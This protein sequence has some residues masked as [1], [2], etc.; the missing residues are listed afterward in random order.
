MPVLEPALALQTLPSPIKLRAAAVPAANLDLLRAVAVL[1]VYLAH[2]AAATGNTNFGSLG[3][4]GVILFF[5]HTSFVLMASLNR[6]SAS[7]PNTASLVRA[8]AVRR[9]FRIYP[10]S[11]ATVLLV[12]VTRIPKSPLDHFLW[13]GWRDLVSNLALTQNL[14]Y[15]RLSLDVLWS[16]PLE[17]QMYCLLPF[18]YLAI[19]SR[20]LLSLSFLVL[21]VVAALTLPRFTGRLVVFAYAP[22]FSA[23]VFGYDIARVAKP[24]LSSSLWPLVLL[25][26]IIAFNPHDDVSLSDK[27]WRAWLVS[28]AIGFAIPWFGEIKLRALRIASHVIAK[29]SYGIYLSH[30]I[31]FWFVF[32]N[33]ASFSIAARVLTLGSGTIL[34]P[35]IMYH[36]IEDP[37]IVLGKRLT[38]RI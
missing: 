19:R 38:E 32:C 2:L 36:L 28:L 15:S 7:S 25:V 14:I 10:L 16:L 18:M 24:K 17:V 26:G 31:V 4:F 34:L 12:T 3:R 9:F 23:G 37:M 33:M 8:F 30:S 21:S 29:Y 13:I 11:I 27:L 20:R 1:S 6:M 35:A 5:V 22:C